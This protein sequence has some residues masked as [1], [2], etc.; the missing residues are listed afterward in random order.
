MIVDYSRRRPQHTPELI[1]GESIEVVTTYKYLGVHLDHKLD[2]SVHTNVA[3]KKR[4]E[5]T[6]LSLKAEIF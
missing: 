5:Q 3:Y 2:W 4:T 1:E 6:L